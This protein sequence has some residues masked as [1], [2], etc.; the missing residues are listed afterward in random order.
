MRKQVPKLKEPNA[1]NLFDLRQLKVPP[2]HFE[3]ISIPMRY[4]LQDSMT[5][6]IT[7]NLKGRFYIGKTVEVDSSNQLATLLQVGFEE[8]KELS[9]FTLACPYLKY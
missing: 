4:N 3:Y 9:Y 7:D 6:W 8:P 5:R 2:A 1:L